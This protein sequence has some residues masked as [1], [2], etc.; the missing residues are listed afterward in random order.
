MVFVVN[1]LLAQSLQEV[2]NF[3]DSLLYLQK[4]SAAINEY[5]RAFFFSESK[6]KQ[7]LSTKISYCCMAQ[8]DFNTAR[9]FSDSAYFYSI[10]DSIKLECRFNKMMSYIL[11]ANYGYAILKIDELE[12]DSSK[13]FKLKKDLYSGIAYFGLGEYDHSF[14]LLNKIL[15]QADTGMVSE[16]NQLI[17]NRRK[18]ERPSPLLAT[19]M[20]TILPGSGQCY[21]GQF[22]S[23]INSLFL[24]TGL[25][26]ITLYMP[27]TAFLIAPFIY[28]YYIGGIIHANRFA[29]MRR[30]HN[31]QDFYSELLLFFPNAQFSASIFDNDLKENHYNHYLENSESEIEIL[32]SLSFIAYKQFFS[33]QDVSVCVFSPSCS[34]YMMEAI[35]KN[36]FLIGYLDGV[37]RLLRC[38]FLANEHHYSLNTVTNK[39]DDIP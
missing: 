8:K 28:R 13:Y 18:L 3:G 35:N 15:A 25:T 9:A 23:G 29:K 26:L 5:Q 19:L 11:E 16:F 30:M 37:D 33:S 38:H 17:E 6:G 1:S 32:F 10:T 27:E 2:I 4:Y 21:T 7:I 31:K 39:Y 12:T 14:K 24:L 22:S 20:S 36:G 34:V